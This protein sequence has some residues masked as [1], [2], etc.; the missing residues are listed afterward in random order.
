MSNR[1]AVVAFATLI[2]LGA[3]ALRAGAGG[4]PAQVCASTKIKVAGKTAACL[5]AVDARVARGQT[6]DSAAL[7]ACRDKLG[8]P[9]HGAFARAESRGGCLATGDAGSIEGKIDAFVDDVDGALAVGTP[10]ACQSAKLRAAARDASCLLGL[11]AKAATGTAL[12]PA[13]VLRCKDRLGGPAGTFPRE[14][15]GG[16]C[17]TSGDAGTIQDEIDAFVDDVVAEEPAVATCASAGCPRRVACD[18]SAGPCWQPPLVTRPQYQLQAAV[19]SSG[20]CAFPATGGIDT[21]ISAVPFTRGPAVGPDVFDIDFLTDPACV[22]GG[23]NDVDDTDAVNAIHARGAHAICYVDA[24]T[25]EPFRPD[26]QAYLDF[27][28]G[29]GGCLL[30]NPVGGFREEHWV[31]IDNDQGQRTFLL[32]IV[33][34][35]IDR[36]RAD[37]FDAVEFDNVDGYANDTGLPFSEATQLLFDTALANLA[38]QKGLTVG[39]KNDLGQIGEL[40]PYFDF[41]INEQCQQYHECA[42]L[43]PFV[44]AGKPVFQVEYQVGAGT[45]C[46]AANDANRSAILKSV[47]LFDVPWTPCR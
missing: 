2:A 43:D 6:A 21:G 30:G 20:D 26:H 35:R 47:D 18:G 16:G 46:P 45:V 28:A 38:H 14:E 22:P 3:P 31:N 5:L 7:Q 44:A 41:A 19:T 11:R 13:R 24:G 8:A 39:L 10:N 15:A 37:G 42:A 29:C 32:G 27:D 4:T 9:L 1:R 34:A 25:D 17:A 12:D 36:C 40:L 33:A 23:S